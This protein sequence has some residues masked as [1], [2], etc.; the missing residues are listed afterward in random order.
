MRPACARPLAAGEAPE[1][2]DELEI[3]FRPAL[4]SSTAVETFELQLVGGS[5]WRVGGVYLEPTSTPEAAARVVLDIYGGETHDDWFAGADVV[6]ATWW[7]PVEGPVFA[8]H[9]DLDLLIAVLG[10]EVAVDLDDGSRV[11]GTL[12]AAH[13]GGR[14]GP[15]VLIHHEGQVRRIVGGHI[16]LGDD[17]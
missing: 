5:L 2:G 1:V 12:L 6:L 11:R 17:A 8:Q 14:R 3:V 13:R 4:A 9:D 16:Y 7:R 10:D 15:I